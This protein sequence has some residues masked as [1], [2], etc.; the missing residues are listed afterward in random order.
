MNRFL[1]WIHRPASNSCRDLS[2]LLRADR[3]T[4]IFV[5]HNLEEAAR[6]SDRVAVIVGG[7]AAAGR[8]ARPR[9]SASRQ[10]GAGRRLPANDAALTPI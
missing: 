1:H 10:I 2:A 8:R 3:R 4:A 9:S 7:R 5:T 6:L